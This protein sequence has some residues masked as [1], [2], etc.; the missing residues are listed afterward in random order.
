MTIQP[1]RSTRFAAW[2]VL[3]QPLATR[4]LNADD[5]QRGVMLHGL[6]GERI[7]TDLS[8]QD[9]RLP[10]GDVVFVTNYH[11]GVLE[12]VAREVTQP[13]WK[14][15]EGQAP[16]IRDKFDPEQPCPKLDALEGIAF[17]QHMRHA[18]EAIRV[19]TSRR[20]KM[21]LDNAYP[22]GERPNI[23]LADIPTIEDGFEEGAPGLLIQHG[24][25]G[26]PMLQA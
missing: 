14:R 25:Q 1:L 15:L 2:G 16:G 10:N 17:L 21:Q 18:G 23:T 22:I 8:V 3:K 13:V 4:Y 6:T 5:K 24:S 26:A 11:V 12:R 19:F 9:R 7:T 20:S